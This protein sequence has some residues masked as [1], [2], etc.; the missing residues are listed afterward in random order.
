MLREVLS[1]TPSLGL[2]L[3][4]C[5]KCTPLVINGIIISINIKME[6]LVSFVGGQVLNTGMNISII[7]RQRTHRQLTYL[8]HRIVLAESI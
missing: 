3:R 6:G 7:I 4:D 8:P 5:N 1:A 2:I